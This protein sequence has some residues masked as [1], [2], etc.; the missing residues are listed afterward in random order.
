MKPLRASALLFFWS[1]LFLSQ[2]LS[3]STRCENL[4]KKDSADY[5]QM[6]KESRGVNY[7]RLSEKII[8]DIDS[9]E[10]TQ[11]SL[12]VEIRD[13]YMLK[14][15]IF[16]MEPCKCCF[17]QLAANPVYNDTNFWTPKNIKKI[18]KKFKINVIPQNATFGYFFYE[19][20]SDGEKSKL[21][22]IY[23]KSKRQKSG[24]Y[25]D[26]S[27]DQQQFYYYPFN[28]KEN[29]TLIDQYPNIN[30]TTL[31]L[32]IRNE[33]GN[34]VSVEYRYDVDNMSRKSVVKLYQYKNGDWKDITRQEYG[35]D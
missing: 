2:R 19:K 30:F 8:S 10:L 32:Y 9:T 20:A 15:P 26:R 12:V 24:I 21:K 18:V 23:R 1:T 28:S 33:V 35:H 34:K 17:E 4:Q 11:P 3:D 29:I 16:N 13:Y 31:R 22:K 27:P 25:K 6:K 7:D 14:K 5:F